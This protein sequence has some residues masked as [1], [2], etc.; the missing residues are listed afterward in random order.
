MIT[1]TFVILN[2]LVKLEKSS[3]ASRWKPWAA[4]GQEMM[5]LL[6]TRRMSRRA[7]EDSLTVMTNVRTTVFWPPLA[8][9]PLSCTV[10][11]MMADPVV[12][13]TGVKLSVPVGLGL[14]YV[15]T[16]FGTTPGV[17]DVA[18]TVSVCDSL[19]A[20]VVMPE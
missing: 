15:M 7:V 18:V 16:G 10:T 12:F 3:R 14:A 13:G 19:A 1:A 4:T 17:S 9:P 8:V 2:Q 20:P 11:V 6:F 5:A